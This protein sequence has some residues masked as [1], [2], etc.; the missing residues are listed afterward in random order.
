MDDDTFGAATVTPCAPKAAS[1]SI[2]RRR[3][4]AI[5]DAGHLQFD[6]AGFEP[7][8]IEDV[9]DQRH[10]TDG[11]ALGERNDLDHVVR[12]GTRGA[13]REQAEGA[14]NRRQ[15]RA[16]FVA[17]GRQKPF[18]ELFHFLEP[19]DCL[20]GDGLRRFE[21]DVF[22]LKHLLDM[23]ALGDVAG[24]GEH[25]LQR[26]IAVVERRRVVGHDRHLAVARA[27]GELVIGD[28]FFPQHSL[29]PGSGA[30]RIGEVVLERRA[31]QLVARAPG[32]RFHLPVDVGDDAGGVSRHQ[33]IDVRFD[34][35]PRVEVLVA[36]AL[37]EF[38][39]LRLDALA[40]GVVGAD[41]EVADDPAVIVAQR[42]DRHD[43]REAAAVLANVGEL[44]DI[45]DS[46][47]SLE[48]QRVETGRNRRPQFR[49]ERVGAGNQFLRV[50]NIGRRDLVENVGSRVAE[51]PFRANV[52]QLD[53]ALVVSG[54]AREVRTVE[55]GVLQ[56]AR[57]E[58]C[59]LAAHVGTRVSVQGGK[60]LGQGGHIG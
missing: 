14:A 43:R 19:F 34:Q 2:A 48:H 40:G 55:D 44:V 4:E 57:L 50:G 51:H 7:L 32:E 42:R 28:L 21:F 39:L 1:D 58:E 11:I 41:Q 15:R 29:D 37:I 18:L 24:R 27:R 12:Q 23:P 17:D 49:A 6:L 59:F 20:L 31:D 9:F 5:G 22:L 53:D 45:F 16:Q 26:A 10:Q 3:I 8:Q 47:R 36:Q 56:R 60:C 52:E 25:A 38:L 13:G 33:G 46:S 54:D 35:R 30:L